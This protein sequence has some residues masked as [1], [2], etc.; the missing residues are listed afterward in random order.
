MKALCGPGRDAPCKLNTTTLSRVYGQGFCYIFKGIDDPGLE[1]CCPPTC[2]EFCGGV[3]CTQGTIWADSEDGLDSTKCCPVHMTRPCGPGA[4]APCLLPMPT[5]VAYPGAGHISLGRRLRIFPKVSGGK[6]TSFSVMPALPQGL[7]LDNKT[8]EIRGS[9]INSSKVDYQTYMIT[10]KNAAGS[11]ASPL[12]FV[13]K[14]AALSYPAATSQ[15]SPGDAVKLVP[16]WAGGRPVGFNITPSLPDG[17]NLDHKTG[18]IRGNAL[19]SAQRN[20]KYSITAWNSAGEVEFD[21]LL[22]F[23]PKPG[24]VSGNA[25]APSF[26]PHPWWFVVAAIT[27]IS[28]MSACM[29]R[30]SDKRRALEEMQEM[31]DDNNKRFSYQPLVP[32]MSVDDRLSQNMAALA[33]PASMVAQGYAAGPYD[34]LPPTQLALTWDGAAGLS[35]MPASNQ[36]PSKL[37]ASSKNEPRVALTW[38]TGDGSEVTV[39]ATGRP[40]GIKFKE[41]LPIRVHRDREGHGKEIGIKVGWVLVAV[42]NV[43]ITAM[44]SYQ[45]VEATLHIELSKLPKIR[46]SHRGSET[47]SKRGTGYRR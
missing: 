19:K 20:Y 21:T 1:A 14:P 39:Y 16:N 15:F 31:E 8:G 4:S 28:I 37:L 7:V 33:S 12:S 34:P 45:E 41:V 35:N 17:L 23:E 30:V 18:E 9:F 27:I 2:G 42:N 26:R 44:S 47:G 25:S 40:L 29:L 38:D 6:P 46:N 13:F 10:A 36:E 5:K 11:T 43:D 3:E 22:P 32:G 24:E